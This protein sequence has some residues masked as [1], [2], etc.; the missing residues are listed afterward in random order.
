MQTQNN[1]ALFPPLLAFLT[2]LVSFTE[3][4]TPVEE[5]L[6]TCQNSLEIQNA[7]TL[8]R[9]ETLRAEWSAVQK[10]FQDLQALG[11]QRAQQWDQTFT[12][13]HAENNQIKRNMTLA[14]GQLKS[15]FSCKAKKEAVEEC[16]S[17]CLFPNGYD[18]CEDSP[19]QDNYFQMY[20]R[21]SGRS[22]YNTVTYT[23]TKDSVEKECKLKI[24]FE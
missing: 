18:T 10:E 11:L 17:F 21:N 1:P 15:K 19:S 5:E 6:A 3:Q 16:L 23:M 4:Y 24:V 22:H 20:A 7:A 13:L 9:L 14:A 2:L 8:S 12:D